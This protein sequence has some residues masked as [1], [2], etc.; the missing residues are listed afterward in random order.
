[1]AVVDIQPLH[2]CDIPTAAAEENVFIVGPIEYPVL[3][4]AC[5]IGDATN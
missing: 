3:M 2:G 4:H 1:M 5:P